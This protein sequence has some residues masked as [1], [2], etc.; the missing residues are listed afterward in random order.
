MTIEEIQE[1]AEKMTEEEQA[2]FFACL[3]KTIKRMAD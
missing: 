3:E 1:L 2:V